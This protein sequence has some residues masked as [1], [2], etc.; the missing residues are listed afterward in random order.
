MVK[1]RRKQEG[2]NPL[3]VVETQGAAPLTSDPRMSGC[4]LQPT[5][6][7]KPTT[8]LGLS[9]PFLSYPLLHIRGVISHL[10]EVPRLV[11]DYERVL[12]NSDAHLQE[13]GG[14][15]E[16]ETGTDQVSC[17][18][19]LVGCGFRKTSTREGTSI[20]NPVP[21]LHLVPLHPHASEPG[22][23][24]GGQDPK[25]APGWVGQGS[26]GWAAYR[27]VGRS[28]ASRLLHPCPKPLLGSRETVAT[29]SQANRIPQCQL[30]PA[31]TGDR[32]G[33]SGSPPAATEGRDSGPCPASA[34]ALFR[35]PGGMALLVSAQDPIFVRAPPEQTR[36]QGRE[37]GSAAL[38][39]S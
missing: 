4:L 23:G 8:P 1:Q 27:K 24:P 31:V 13:W 11:F 16:P 19:L 22:R 38:F 32:G 14:D 17:H 5:L 3:L 6:H 37:A 10:A 2:G 21:I 26:E 30:R 35:P 12:P 18:G 36:R 29:A 20:L 15:W 28:P 7:H 25:E 34:R 9:Q 39:P 33:G